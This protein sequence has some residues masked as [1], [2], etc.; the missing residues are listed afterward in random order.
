VLLFEL[1]EALP[2]Q[3]ICL[4]RADVVYEFWILAVFPATKQKANL[5]EHQ[6]HANV[7]TIQW[8]EYFGSPNDFEKPPDS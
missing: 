6:P 5:L 4:S 1:A 3:F 7:L 2:G 8:S